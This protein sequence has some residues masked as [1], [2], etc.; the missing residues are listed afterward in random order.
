MESSEPEGRGEL[1]IQHPPTPRAGDNVAKPPRRSYRGRVVGAAALLLLIG[2][3][4]AAVAIWNYNQNAPVRAVEQ[5]LAALADADLKTLKTLVHTEADA[6]LLTQEILD[7]SL[8]LAPIRTIDVANED[9]V[10]MAAFSVGDTDV[11]RTFDVKRNG[12]GWLI[13]DAL[14][15]VPTYGGFTGANVQINGTPLPD[16][17]TVV[18][19]GTYQIS[20]GS[21]YFALYGDTEFVLATD[22]DVTQMQQTKVVLSD[23][24]VKTFA[25]LVST[26]LEECLAMTGASTPCGIDVDLV[27]VRGTFTEG[28]AQR[29]LASEDQA[30]LGNLPVILLHGEL[31]TVRVA[32]G[33]SVDL[34]FRSQDGDDQWEYTS[35]SYLL[36]PQVDF[37]ADPIRLSWIH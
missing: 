15:A 14:T 27:K 22:A 16:G 9:G 34:T 17:D 4:S 7:A 32:Q 26:S 12:E 36:W 19:P 35:Q 20:L 23:K 29:T 2:G 1:L 28:S 11:S 30:A 25:E 31:T 13:T 24:G 37:A 3:A 5:F 33:L 10:I 21:D 18:F 8:E 6:S